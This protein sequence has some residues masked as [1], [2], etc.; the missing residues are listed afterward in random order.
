MTRLAAVAVSAGLAILLPACG[1]LGTGTPT[2]APARAEP[3]AAPGEPCHAAPSTRKVLRLDRPRA[4]AVDVACNLFV[5]DL[6]EN[7]VLRVTADGA[8][9]VL[10]GGGRRRALDGAPAAQVRIGAPESLAVDALGNVYIGTD[11]AR[12]LRVSPDGLLRTAAGS[13]QCTPDEPPAG[14]ALQ[15]VICLPAALAVDATGSL[16]IADAGNRYLSRLSPEGTITTLAGNGERHSAGD[17]G[18]ATAAAIGDPGGLAVGAAGVVFWSDGYSGSVRSV[19]A[20]GTVRTVAGGGAASPGETAP[21]LF[22]Q[23]LALDAAG[24]LYVADDVNSRV[25]RF[26]TDGLLVTVAG[27]GP[28]GL[29]GDHGPASAAALNLPRAI[30]FDRSGSLYIADTGNDRVRRVSTTGIISTVN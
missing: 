5:A 4:L 7:R 2:R 23:G 1:S 6:L 8:V 25:L 29:R 3:A 14:P 16:L 15:A 18:H 26:T 22:P 13:G 11:E 19:T 12:V 17:G 24:S 30:A 27:T 10:A 21:E 20:D 28:P 9:S